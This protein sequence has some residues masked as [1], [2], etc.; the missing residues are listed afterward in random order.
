MIHV[1]RIISYYLSQVHFLQIHRGLLHSWTSLS[2]N[3]SSLP[4]VSTSLVLISFSSKFPPVCRSPA[5]PDCM[6]VNSCWSSQCIKQLTSKHIQKIVLK[7]VVDKN[8]AGL[9]P[10]FN[11]V[12]A[13]YMLSATH[14]W[15]C[16]T[17]P[18][19]HVVKRSLWWAAVEPSHYSLCP[20]RKEKKIKIIT[21]CL[22]E[23]EKIQHWFLCIVDIASLL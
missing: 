23:S 19:I 10:P 14:P 13:S 16:N 11:I 4:A 18:R 9:F 20:G 22:H 15:A 3:V 12:P 7:G 5:A 8:E 21:P 6:N 2:L 1:E 17:W